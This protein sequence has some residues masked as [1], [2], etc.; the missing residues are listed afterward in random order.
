MVTD[1]NQT[2]HTYKED[3]ASEIASRV[4]DHAVLLKSW[5][6]SVDRRLEFIRRGKGISEQTP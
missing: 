6:D 1:R 4:K 5:L 3:V 2:V